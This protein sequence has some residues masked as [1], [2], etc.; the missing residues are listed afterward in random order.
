M[1]QVRTRGRPISKTAVN[2]AADVL[3]LCLAV[4][5]WGLL[6]GSLAL[7]MG[8]DLWQAQAMS[9]FVFAGAAQLSG[10]TMI[11]G[12]TGYTALF[13]ST[14]V[15]SSRHMLYSANFRQHVLPLP[16]KWR[17]SLGFV[18]TDEMY[19]LSVH[20]NLRCGYFDRHYAL[21]SGLT[22]YLFWNLATL[23]GI[24]LGSQ[25]SGLEDMGFEFAIA[26]TFIALVVPNVRNRASLGC[27]LVSGVSMLVF[28]SLGFE[29]SLLAATACGMLTGY[30]VE[31]FTG[32]EAGVDG[33]RL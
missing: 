26:A 1:E 28:E 11:G 12:G 24:L 20:H 25:V 16:L 5:P 13:G 10:I 32:N 3:P 19:A 4:L 33:E 18:L 29:Q 31:T 17:L 7:Q 27:V 6:C 14:A 21:I 23:A 8:L 9:L 30:A 22:F 2:A 15:I